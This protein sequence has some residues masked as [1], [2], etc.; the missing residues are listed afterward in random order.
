MRH[1]KRLFYYLIINV[2]VSACTVVTV[3]ALWQRYQPEIPFLGDVNPLALITPMSPQALFP[4]YVSAAE[5]LEPT[6]IPVKVTT[7]PLP[8]ETQMSEMTYTVQT[9]DT[10]G[11]IAVKFNITVAEITAANEI[12]N[13]D[14]LVVG[15]V[16]IIRRPLVAVST[17]TALPPEEFEDELEA[18][19][20]PPT[21]TPAPLTG[22]SRV[23]IDSVIGAGDLASERI[24]L[25]RVG[26]GELALTGWELV[27]ENGETFTFPQLI[28]FESGAVFIHSREG[29]TTAVALYWELDHSVWNSGD[30][31]VLID[32]Q[33]E[34]HA[35]Y[36][37]P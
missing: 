9:G 36:E 18:T 20:T 15:Q 29:Q 24:F 22:D 10:L 3:L 5:T 6:A 16:L 35:S 28:L 34:V 4:D 14:S 32:D 11:E 12:S 8:A 2:F 25:K 31:V 23:V 7:E 21:N 33:G 19:T 17:R 26:P 30:T 1:W 13:P 37:I 27:A